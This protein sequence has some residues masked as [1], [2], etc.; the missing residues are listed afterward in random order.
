M[1]IATEN[2]KIGVNLYGEKFLKG[3]FL[4]LCILPLSGLLA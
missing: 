2:S 4:Q 1:S 3:D